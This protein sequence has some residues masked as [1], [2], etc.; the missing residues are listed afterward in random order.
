MLADIAAA[1]FSRRGAIAW[2]AAFALLFAAL[3]PA[4]VM[5]WCLRLATG[6]RV[7]ISAPAG[8]FWN[9]SGFVTATRASA[10]DAPIRWRLYPFYLLMGQLR[11]A[12]SQGAAEGLVTIAPGELRL[13]RIDLRVPAGVLAQA[14]EPLV[15]AQLGGEAHLRSD[16]MLV[17]K[18]EAAGNAQLQ[19]SNATSALVA[20]SA[21]GSYEIQATGADR[22]V[23]IESKTV[24][25]ALNISGTGSWTWSD[26]FAFSGTLSA[27]PAKQA[28][29]LSLLAVA[30]SPNSAGGVELRWP[31]P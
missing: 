28:E 12:L 27:V 26:G 19:L 2:S 18:T 10:G 29:L 13:A 4:S 9:G 30:G 22:R 20:S 21:L 23:R 6:G 7:G 31:R 24:S 25:G 15:K 16:L 5:D 1:L 14:W 3:A 17:S 8:T 11:I